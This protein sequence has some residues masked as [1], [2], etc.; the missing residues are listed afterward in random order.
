[1]VVYFVYIYVTHIVMWEM[2]MA[3]AKTLDVSLSDKTSSVDFVHITAGNFWL[4]FKP[5][6]G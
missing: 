4:H 2:T 5:L 6:G 3:M 1:M